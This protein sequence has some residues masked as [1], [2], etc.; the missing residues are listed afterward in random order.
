[1]CLKALSEELEGEAFFFHCPLFCIPEV[2]K[3]HVMCG[4]IPR[5][6]KNMSFSLQKKSR[7]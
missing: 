5:T 7:I 6:K 4:L 3:F 1:M 2:V